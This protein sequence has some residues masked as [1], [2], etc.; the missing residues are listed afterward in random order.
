MFQEDIGRG[1]WTEERSF[2]G[3]RK[4][5]KKSRGME[6]FRAAALFNA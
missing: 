5:A 6:V 3:V 4:R 2:A 1:L